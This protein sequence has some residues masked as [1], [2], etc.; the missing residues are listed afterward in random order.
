MRMPRPP[1]LLLLRG[2]LALRRLGLL[3]RGP[4]RRLIALDALL[5]EVDDRARHRGVVGDHGHAWVASVSFTKCAMSRTRKPTSISAR[6]ANMLRCHR[7][8]CVA[9]SVRV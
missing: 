6:I 5:G 7:L 1:H 4:P 2:G 3:H 9:P 8:S